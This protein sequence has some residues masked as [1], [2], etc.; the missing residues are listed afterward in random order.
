MLFAELGMTIPE[1]NEEADIIFLM[2]QG[3]L[4]NI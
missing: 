2:K 1:Y 3:I 4:E